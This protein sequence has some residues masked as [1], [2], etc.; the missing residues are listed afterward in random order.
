MASKPFPKS[1]TLSGVKDIIRHKNMMH[2][3]VPTNNQKFSWNQVVL[4]C[5]EQFQA[6]P[7][8][9]RSQKELTDLY[10]LFKEKIAMIY[11]GFK[12]VK[13]VSILLENICFI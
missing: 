13:E 8:S 10:S 4:F 5:S 12:T 7:F 3:I 6:Q 2:Y 1:S 11:T 9:Y